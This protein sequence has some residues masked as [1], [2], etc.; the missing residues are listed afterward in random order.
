MPHS[1]RKNITYLFIAHDLGL[2]D[3]MCHQV[4]V[5]YLGNVVEWL[6]HGRIAEHCKHPYTKALMGA[7][8]KVDFKPGE[9]IEP[10]EGEIPKSAGPAAGMS[11]CQPLRA[12]HRALRTG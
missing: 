3:L 9:K 8:F 7:V 1:K 4:A 10:L 6:E 5:M 12:L 2:V 11:L